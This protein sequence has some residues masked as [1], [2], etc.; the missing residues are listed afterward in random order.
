MLTPPWLR[1]AVNQGGDEEVRQRRARRRRDERTLMS[2]RYYAGL[3]ILAVR[4]EGLS[5]AAAAIH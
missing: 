5:V 1:G 2:D 3:I 4:W